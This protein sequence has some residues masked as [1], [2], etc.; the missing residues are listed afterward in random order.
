MTG[1]SRR[2]FLGASALLSG[3]LATEL[4]AAAEA[5]DVQK[6]VAPLNGV[7]PTGDLA[8]RIALSGE[9]LTTKG[10]PAYSDPMVLADVTLDERRRFYN[11]SGDTSGRYL[12]ALSLMPAPW[13]VGGKHDGAGERG[14]GESAGGWA[15]WADRLGVYRGGDR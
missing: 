1:W 10:L 12:E 6:I 9:R 8:A 5:A 14:S 15:V 13:P 3:S 11:F 2:E 4:L 7:T